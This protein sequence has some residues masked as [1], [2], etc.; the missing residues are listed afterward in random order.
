M[1]SQG[2]EK[3]IQLNNKNKNKQGCNCVSVVNVI[4]IREV[5]TAIVRSGN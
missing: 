1:Y 5:T 3:S 2:V 4:T